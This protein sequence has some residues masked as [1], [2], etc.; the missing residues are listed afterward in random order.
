MTRQR[1]SHAATAIASLMTEREWMA[2]V[3]QAAEL[4]GWTWVHFR[5]A[6]TSKGWRTPV[7]GPNGA[8]Y[9]DL[10]LVR[11]RIIYAELKR[12]D[13]RLDP[14]QKAVHDRYRAAGADVRVW[15]PSDLPEVL[16]ALR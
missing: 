16:E 8:G 2:Q 9:F 7:S 11:D 13:G 14:S 5:P 1:V 10:E 15:R 6:Q 4:Y 3:T 12:Q